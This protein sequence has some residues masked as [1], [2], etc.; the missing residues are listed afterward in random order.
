MHSV[1]KQ[2]LK[3]LLK[4]Q[5]LRKILHRLFFLSLEADPSTFETFEGSTLASSIEAMESSIEGPL[6]DHLWTRLEP[7]YY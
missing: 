6:S 3:S 1:V 4:F 7:I 5:L 2:G